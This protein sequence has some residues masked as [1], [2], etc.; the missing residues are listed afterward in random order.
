MTRENICLQVVKNKACLYTFTVFNNLYFSVWAIWD[1]GYYNIA[2]QSY[3]AMFLMLQWLCNEKIEYC[4]NIKTCSI[5][6]WCSEKQ[7]WHF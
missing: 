7:F 6:Y 2:L 3:I 4:K 1:Q 5:F